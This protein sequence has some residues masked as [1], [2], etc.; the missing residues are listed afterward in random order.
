MA[1]EISQAEQRRFQVFAD[2]HNR[3]WGA[4][5]D[6]RTGHAVGPFSPRF[7]AP[8]YPDSQ[9]IRHDPNDQRKIII[10]YYA[11][12]T[13][14]DDAMG[15]YEMNR[16]RAAQSLYGAAFTSMLGKTPYDDPPELVNKVGAPPMS[17]HFPAAAQEGNQWILGFSEKVPKWAQE[18]LDREAAKRNARLY[19][20]ADD[21][22]DIDEQFDPDATGGKTEPVGKRKKVA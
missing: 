12:V 15:E 14:R 3:D 17:R 6:I 5:I 13:E 9:F 20:D 16:L 10:D 4:P 8:W 21:A 7:K 22:V 18:I 19:L 11:I 2:Q 1:K